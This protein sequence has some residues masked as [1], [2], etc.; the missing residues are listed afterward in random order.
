M[1]NLDGEGRKWERHEVPN[2]DPRK[3]GAYHSLHV[4]DMDGDGDFDIMSSEMEGVP[5][6]GPPRWY[7]WEN[8][9]GRGGSWKEHVILDANLGGHQ[10]L[11]G[12]I[13]GNGKP[14]II[15]KPWNANKNN[16]LGGR[17]FVVFLENQSSD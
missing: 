13:T 6:D 12:D 5:G 10:T 14:D 1:E 7:I 2:G 16:A 11:V 3:R 4:G 15:S 17:V 8:L 9:D